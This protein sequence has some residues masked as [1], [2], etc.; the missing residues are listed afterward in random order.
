MS[1]NFNSKN[2]ITI[3]KLIFVNCRYLGREPYIIDSADFSAQ[4]RLRLYWHNLPFNPFMPLFENHQ[5]VQDTLTP[6][7][8]RKA[9]CKKLQTV[10]GRSGS[11]LQGI[12]VH[13]WIFLEGNLYSTPVFILG[14]AELKPIMMKGKTDTIWVTE[15]EEIFGFPRHYTDVKNLSA[16]NRQKL[17]GKSW[18]VQTLT[19][20]LRPLC[21]YFKCNEDETSK[22]SAF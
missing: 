21:S 14:K 16:T 20:I 2:N 7:L 11:L 9:L 12:F 5:D 19:A 13:L 22:K 8:N 4:H 15:L 18:S 3:T 17:L 6:N 10:T 1:C